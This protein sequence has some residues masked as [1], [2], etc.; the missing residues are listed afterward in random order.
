MNKNQDI[1]QES[2]MNTSQLVENHSDVGFAYK[3]FIAGIIGLLA[4]IF[5]LFVLLQ[6][7]QRNLTCHWYTINLLVGQLPQYNI[8]KKI[9]NH[10]VD[11][12]MLRVVYELCTS[13]MCL[14][15]CVNNSIIQNSSQIE[16]LIIFT[17]IMPR[18]VTFNHFIEIYGYNG[19]VTLY[20]L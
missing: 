16:L 14:I 5:L 19:E 17:Y 1:I 8:K 2:K 9:S 10:L 20:Y 7:K 6:K 12:W 4:N 13:I 18:A 3:M 15:V 11:V